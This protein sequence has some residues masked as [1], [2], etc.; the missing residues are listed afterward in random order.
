MYE[1]WCIAYKEELQD[2]Y[3]QVK[4]NL[5]EHEIYL[6][7]YDVFTWFVYSVSSRKIPSDVISHLE[8]S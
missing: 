6:T 7:D 5:Q 1:L 2:L 4:Q 3:H 8:L